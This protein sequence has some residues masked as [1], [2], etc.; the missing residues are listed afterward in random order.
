MTVNTKTCKTKPDTKLRAIFNIVSLSSSTLE[1][2][3]LE[4]SAVL[5]KLNTLFK[6]LGDEEAGDIVNASLFPDNDETIT[7]LLYC[8]MNW[9]NCWTDYATMIVEKLLDAGAEFNDSDNYGRTPLFFL[10][11]FDSDCAAVTKAC[12]QSCKNAMEKLIKAGAAVDIEEDKN[13]TTSLHWACEDTPAKF[14]DKV[15][16]VVRLLLEAGANVNAFDSHK[17]TPLHYVE[18]VEIAKLLLAAGAQIDHCRM[19]QQPPLLHTLF[20]YDDD[21]KLF[22]HR[23]NSEHSQRISN[24]VVFLI[25]KGANIM[26][27][28]EN[29][30]KA[31][32]CIPRVMGFRVLKTL[33]RTL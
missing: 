17:K 22:F 14:I 25:D 16:A 27:N 18:D 29:G 3:K 11:K 5:A 30:I 31:I 23:S 9:H 20:S 21:S 12:L 32:D 28:D 26:I 19:G 8:V 1:Q 2:E 13:G 15:A 24:L 10:A 4:H 7:P 33:L 6:E